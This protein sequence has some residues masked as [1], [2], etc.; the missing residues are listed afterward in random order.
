MRCELT[1]D[2]VVFFWHWHG[3]ELG[4]NRISVE[5][6]LMLHMT[7]C[8]RDYALGKRGDGRGDEE[9]KV[10]IFLFFWRG[11][12]HGC[13]FFFFCCFNYNAPTYITVMHP[14]Y[15]LL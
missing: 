10:S 2:G 12:I 5:D 6:V 8:E 1:G 7:V 3:I 9:K 4:M 15:F 11:G 14:I 13:F